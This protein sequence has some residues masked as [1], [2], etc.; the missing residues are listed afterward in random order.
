MCGACAR[1]DVLLP[2]RPL[3]RDGSVGPGSAAPYIA[4]LWALELLC[5]C[6]LV[7]G[8]WAWR[9]DPARRRFCRRKL[10]RA[11]GPCGGAAAAARA[12]CAIGGSCICRSHA[13]AIR[14]ATRICLLHLRQHHRARAQ[15][16]SGGDSPATQASAQPLCVG[17][18]TRAAKVCWGAGARALW[19]GRGKR[20]TSKRKLC[21]ALGVLKEVNSRYQVFCAADWGT[22]R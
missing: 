11:V 2:H 8:G 14:A 15:Q 13:S 7:A 17:P 3:P 6:R 21:G 18:S 10:W 19:L 22:I 20:K 1:R 4:P 16:I 9:R 12:P 5:P